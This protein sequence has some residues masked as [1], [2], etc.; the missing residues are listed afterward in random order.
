MTNKTSDQAEAIVGE[1]KKPRLDGNFPVDQYLMDEYDPQTGEVRFSKR[2]SMQ[3][4][5]LNKGGQEIPDPR[6]A[7]PS[8]G[9]KPEM[10]IRD[11]IRTMVRSE[12]LQQDL[13]NQGVE[14]FE[15]A[16]DFEVGEDYF[17]DS[18]YENDLEPSVTEL[19]REG[20]ASLSAKARADERRKYEDKQETRKERLRRELAE[21][22]ASAPPEPKKSSRGARKGA[23]AEPE[24]S[25]ND[26]QNAGAEPLPPD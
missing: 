6:P 12:R 7:A 10:H 23:A 11:Y 13:D 3:D 21:L 24:G 9:K 18:Q 15:E 26:D 14:T 22:E 19:I 5:Y 8:L 4:R 2:V 25:A 20:T 1:T 16:N 17:P